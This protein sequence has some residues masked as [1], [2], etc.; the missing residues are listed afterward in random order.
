[1]TKNIEIIMSELKNKIVIFS[2]DIY[3]YLSMNMNYY[4]EIISKIEN[5]IFIL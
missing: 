1:M 2:N 5:S 3:Y 4:R